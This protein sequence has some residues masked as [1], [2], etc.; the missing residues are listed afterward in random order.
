MSTG[1]HIADVVTDSFTLSA[2]AYAATIFG[3]R[4]S[5]F[6]GR[7]PK[8]VNMY[9]RRFHMST[10]PLDDQQAFAAWLGERWNEKDKLLQEFM[11]TGR[12]PADAELA[13][14]NDVGQT[15]ADNGYINTEVRLA[16]WYEVGQVFVTLAAVALIA[17]IL[18]KLWNML[19]SPLR[20]W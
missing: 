12:F 6:Q 17:D 5:Y 14:K 8:S 4:S 13:S 18:A 15:K 7:P 2:G 20:G 11:D 16:N 1:I 3:L 10:I 19:L 9:W